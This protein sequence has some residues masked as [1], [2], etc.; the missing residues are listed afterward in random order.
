MAERHESDRSPDFDLVIEAGRGLQAYSRDLWRYRGLFLFLAWR[1]VLVLYKQTAI[2]VAWAVLRP[3]ITMVVFTVVFGRIAGLPS[4]G[5]PYPI[6]VFAAMIP[7]QMFANAL[8]ESSASLV[9]N[10]NLVTKVYFPR[11]VVPAS[12]IAATVVDLCISLLILLVMMLAYRVVPTWRL[13]VVPAF[14]ALGLLL[15]FGAGTWFSA[16]SVRYRDFRYVV[17][18]IVQLGLYVSPVGFSVEVV[19]AR[20]RL[21]YSMNPMVGVIDGFRWA[22]TGGATPLDPTSIAATIGWS[23]SLCLS[24][25][26]YFR[27]VE[28]TLA[29]VI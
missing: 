15:A 13:V 1:D 27:G 16:L 28:R 2:G 22:I 20:W 19:P 6:L 3:L 26:F 24:G 9:S 4:H 17:P 21:L 11:I 29:D 10:A 12:A 14:A 18:F 8:T 25:F 23:V 5:V 7:W